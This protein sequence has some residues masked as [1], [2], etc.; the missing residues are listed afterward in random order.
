MCG[1]LGPY[2]DT[3]VYGIFIF[4][5]ARVRTHTRT[6]TRG[7]LKHTQ[8]VQE[9]G[10]AHT[11]AGEQIYIHTHKW[12]AI[13]PTHIQTQRAINLNVHQH[14]WTNAYITVVNPNFTVFMFIY[15]NI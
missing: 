5:L 2:A 14:T 10:R 8:T 4:S 1:W 7:E 15:A 13:I 3:T 6:G 9:H 12:H 11:H